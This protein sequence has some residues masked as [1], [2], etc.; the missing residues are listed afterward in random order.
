MGT[1]KVI[2]VEDLTNAHAWPEVTSPEVTWPFS[3]LFF[4]Y[5]PVLFSCTF[6]PYFF[7]P[8]FI[9]RTFFPVFPS[10]FFSVL[11]PRTFSKVATFEIQRLKIS[12]SCFSSTCR[13]QTVHVPC[14]ISIQTS[15]VGLPLDGWDSRMV[16]CIFPAILFSLCASS[17]LIIS[18]N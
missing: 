14:K 11:F 10:Y 13:Y 6:F 1:N 4:P 2:L 5:F 15:P 7:P 17:N 18:T 8:Y 16:I 3:L 9:S 12:V